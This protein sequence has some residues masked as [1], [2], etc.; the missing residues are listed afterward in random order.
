M[1]TNDSQS[2]LNDLFHFRYLKHKM[3]SLH[4]HVNWVKNIEYSR[5][6][7]YLATSGFDGAVFLWD[8]NR[9]SEDE[10]SECKLMLIRF[11]IWDATGILSE[12]GTKLRDWAVGQ[13]GGSCYSQA[14]LSSNDSKTWYRVSWM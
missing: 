14:A 10:V 4:G 12:I 13:A 1:R 8:I 9:H 11:A 5:R 2:T 6:E 3:R 7:Q